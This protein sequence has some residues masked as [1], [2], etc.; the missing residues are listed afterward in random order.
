MYR[1]GLDI[2]T[3]SVCGICC[4]GKTGEIRQT[5]TRPN[6]GFIAG[7]HSWERLQD[8][9]ALIKE[10][11][12]IASELLEGWH[13]VDSI[14][15]TGQ[16]HGI[17]YI[18]ASGNPVSPLY[19]WQDGRGDRPYKD[20][21][22]YTEWL[23]RLTGYPLATGY[24][25]VTHFYNMVNG[26]VP[27]T[28]QTFCTIHDLAA[29]ALSGVTKPVLHP[30]D[31]ASFGMYDL[32]TNRFDERAIASTGMDASFFPKVQTGYRILGKTTE[33]IPVSVAI[34]DNQA[35]VLGSIRD[36][37]NS[38]LINVG[39][40]SQISCVVPDVPETSNL[41]CRPLT[42]G[43]YILAG[44]SL[45]GGRAYAILERFLRET[46]S[47]VADLKVES[48]YGA[49]ESAMEDYHPASRH[50]LKVDT[51]FG[52]TREEPE[53]RGAIYG[54]DTD[55]LTMA[56]LCDG[57]MNGMVEELYEMYQQ[58]KPFLKKEPNRIVGSGNGIRLNRHLAQRFRD[59]FGL[60]LFIPVHKEEAAF[61]AAL[62][63]M[64]A[65]GLSDSMEEAQRL[66]RYC[67]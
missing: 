46:A 26:L 43:S 23:S 24:G 2:G 50:G 59:I 25:A 47:I 56:N 57:V 27:D 67:E 52:G 28:A 41:D 34:G 8:A 11:K 55:N 9:E 39:T 33:E 40:G 49:M 4:D 37:E 21:H 5:I 53:K 32:K 10:V 45:C 15:V 1:I 35:S 31:A 60:P 19:T 58:M 14:G 48:A 38:L 17:V 54:I 64:C 61:G 29:M 13:E 7:N 18:D 20:G 30:S 66:I 6:P 12:E 42:D 51:T 62:F 3:T 65:A 22:T 16:M 63:G 36:M 44:S